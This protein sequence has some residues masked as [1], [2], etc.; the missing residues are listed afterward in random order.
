[1][2]SVQVAP[3]RQGLLSAHHDEAVTERYILSDIDPY[4]KIKHKVQFFYIVSEFNHS[5]EC[6]NHCLS[7]RHR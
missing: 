1:M 2:I 5:G 3:F 7:Q 4:F 6:F